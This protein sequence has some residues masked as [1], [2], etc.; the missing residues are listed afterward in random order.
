M[1]EDKFEK[2]LEVYSL[3]EILELAGIEAVEVLH[4]LDEQG[5]LEDLDLLEPL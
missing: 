3:E 1:T 2:L 4:V 5:Y